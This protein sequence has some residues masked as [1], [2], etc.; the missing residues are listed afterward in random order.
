MEIST[1]EEIPYHVAVRKHFGFEVSCSELLKEFWK[2]EY[3]KEKTFDLKH[4]AC[5]VLNKALFVNRDCA[6]VLSAGK[7]CG[8][9]RNKIQQ[10]IEADE[11]IVFKKYKAVKDE[12]K[13]IHDDLQRIENKIDSNDLRRLTK[14]CI[15]AANYKQYCSYNQLIDRAVSCKT[16]ILKK[17][18]DGRNDLSDDEKKHLMNNE[19]LLKEFDSL[20]DIEFIVKK[21]KFMH[22][23]DYAKEFKDVYQINK[24]R[25]IIIHHGPT[26]TGKTHDGIEEIVKS[27]G[28]CIYAAPLRL[29]AFEVYERLN[30]R[31]ILC[32]LVT[33]EEKQIVD[34]SRV[35]SCTVEA[36]D[37]DKSYDV[38][39]ID[40]CHLVSDRDRGKNWTKAL[41]GLNAEA[42]HVCCDS[43]AVEIIKKISNACGDVCEE[44]LHVRK[45]PLIVDEENF[46]YPKSVRKGDAMIVFS[47]KMCLALST[48]LERLG[49]RTSVI[50]GNL[51]PKVRKRQ[52]E[53]FNS[54]ETDVVVATDAIG[55]GLNMPIR[56]VIFM[57]DTKFDGEIRRFL[58][59]FE[60]KQISGR[61][62]RY[63]L[64]EQGLVSF[65]KNKDDIHIDRKILE[66][67]LINP[68]ENIER[69]YIGIHDG[70]YGKCSDMRDVSLLLSVWNGIKTNS[71]LYKKENVDRQIEILF[72]YEDMFEDLNFDG[73]MIHRLFNT[74]LDKY[75]CEYVVN[76][77]TA[78]CGGLV[79]PK[80]KKDNG[81]LEDMERYSHQIDVYYSIANNFSIN[82][83]AE[84]HRMEKDGTSERIL[85]YLIKNSK[86]MSNKCSKCGCEMEWTHFYS[87]CEECYSRNR[88]YHYYDDDT[89][90]D[91]DL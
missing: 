5:F 84:W 9:N 32:N 87:M 57:E 70:I 20:D 40:E 76:S 50:Y 54:G 39:V 77:M 3:I 43:S 79:L 41:L 46:E 30:Q 13:K 24:K 67:A 51:P 36:I 73:R 49:I 35:V 72:T 69:A 19:S 1:D 53:R 16:N 27:S 59:N 26:N 2:S 8:I 7:E 45:T 21:M 28:Q 71:D 34:G 82:Y 89:Y 10:R 52:Y 11:N 55:M 31:G 91:F 86:K 33:G 38:A 83:D 64:F 80:P 18:L 23:F 65:C 75:D 14:I 42:I 15:L 12:I 60:L 88:S 29:L 81:R 58:N 25:K 62:G 48:D 6:G 66:D 56:R 78:I 90:D 63:G 68:L 4:Q 47:R 85:K 44:I 74:T 61:A 37:Y 17:E 22:E